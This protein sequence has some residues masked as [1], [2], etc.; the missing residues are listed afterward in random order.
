MKKGIKLSVLTSTAVLSG[1][2]TASTL[3]HT[4]NADTV[5]SENNV[6]K[7]VS[8]SKSGNSLQNSVYKLSSQKDKSSENNLSSSSS[9]SNKTSSLSKTSSTVNT[10]KKES[11][12]VSSTK[13]VSEKVS[14]KASSATNISEKESPKVVSNVGSKKQSKT[15]DSQ[16][17]VLDKESVDSYNKVQFSENYNELRV[18]QQ[19]VATNVKARSTEGDPNV[20]FD[21]YVA[22][23]FFTDVTQ[24]NGG[25]CIFSTWKYSCSLESRE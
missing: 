9:V 17:N 13:N 10:L 3:L 25:K 1:I 18:N 11:S 24:K 2:F 12:K 7:N 8:S 4:V 5:S 21:K 20:K 23:I 14:S 6:V 19:S 15:K 16:S 22:R